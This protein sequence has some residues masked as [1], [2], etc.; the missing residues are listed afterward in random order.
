MTVLVEETSYNAVFDGVN[1]A[2]FG[3]ECADKT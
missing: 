1:M 2:V 3:A